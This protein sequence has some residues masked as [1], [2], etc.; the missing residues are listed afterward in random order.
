MLQLA[1]QLTLAAFISH[2]TC[3]ADYAQAVAAANAS[4]L[5]TSIKVAVAKAQASATASNGEVSRE[6]YMS[7]V[8][9]A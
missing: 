2:S 3:A 8:H 4:S 5:T 7:G 6:R 9:I 1:G